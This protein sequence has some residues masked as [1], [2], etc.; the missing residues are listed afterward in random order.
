MEDISLQ[1]RVFWFSIFPDCTFNRW[2]DRREIP[3]VVDRVWFFR[4]EGKWLRPVDDTSEAYLELFQPLKE[5]A[6]AEQAL[7][8]MLMTPG[9]LQ[10]D[11]EFVS[12]KF[13]FVCELVGT[14]M[15][16]E[17]LNDVQKQSSEKVKGEICMDLA[18]ID[19]CTYQDCPRTLLRFDPN[20]AEE[21]A[22]EVRRQRGAEESLTEAAITGLLNAR[23]PGKIDALRERLQLES[24]N[25]NPSIRKRAAALLQKY[26][27]A[28]GPMTCTACR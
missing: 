3:G 21:Q 19:H 10:K 6:N 11:P 28:Y 13:G 23:E 18:L 27:L 26:F 25:R 1:Q 16:F 12:T 4:R 5:G 2:L 15:C 22:K 17:M 9:A 7:I 24:C 14:K 8:R 20:S